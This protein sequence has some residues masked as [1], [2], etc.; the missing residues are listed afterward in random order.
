MI[1]NCLNLLFVIHIGL[2]GRAFTL[3]IRNWGPGKTFMPRWAPQGLAQL[4][5]LHILFL[6]TK[7]HFP[8][9]PRWLL[10][11]FAQ[12][13]LL[14]DSFSS[15]QWLNCVHVTPWTAACQASLSFTNSWSLLKL[16]SIKSVMPINHLILCCPLL[17][18]PPIFHK[19]L[20]K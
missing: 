10:Q 6:L 8:Q 13:H 15:V 18:L 2:G 16:M 19:G 17:L 4:E 20:L 1:S 12:C 3:Q 5:S 11:V 7:T 9:I 14:S